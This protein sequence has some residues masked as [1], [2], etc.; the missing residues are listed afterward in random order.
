MKRNTTLIIF[1]LAAMFVVLLFA[2][3][4]TA[5]ADMGPKPSIDITFK[6]LG[7]ELCYATILSQH[8]TTGPYSAYYPDPE[9]EFDYRDF[10]MYDSNYYND[11][12]YH[13]EEVER[14]WQTF[15]DYQDTDGYYFL[16]LWWKLDGETDNIRWGYYPPY[17]FK[18]LLYYPEKDIFVTSGIYERYAFDS[19]YTVDMSVANDILLNPDSSGEAHPNPDRNGVVELELEKSYDYTWEI[20]SLLC[21]I[22]LT[23]A[24]EMAVAL[25]F[26]IKGRKPLLTIL[27]TNCVTQIAL[28][29]ALNLLCYFDGALMIIFLYLPLELGVIFVEAVTY[30][31]ALRKQGVPIW[32]A[33]LY[34]L[35][36]N[37]VSGGLGF[38]LA[39]FLPGLF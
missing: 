18:L 14:I 31:I 23:I 33:L 6:N 19:Y 35:V 28:N 22:I 15:V 25:L 2:E 26:R 8:K 29:V 38:A 3:P 7:D 12:D 9:G 11:P 17:S 30:A 16:Q 32:K 34:A 20:I 21:R 5:N 1:C 27:I 37:V 24:I 10:G 13:N 39:L 36:A 4:Q